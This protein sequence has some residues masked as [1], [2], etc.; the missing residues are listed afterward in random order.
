MLVR[1]VLFLMLTAVMAQ[2]P[3]PVSIGE[4]HYRIFRGDGTAATLEQLVAEA[5]AG[6]VTF[7][8]EL[9]DD[10]V[11]HYL[12]LR[13][14]REMWTPSLALSLEM[15]ETD[16]QD[17]LD[18]YLAGLITEQ[19][20]V[21]ASRPWRNYAQDYRPLIEFAKE[22]KMA[23]VAANAPR[24]YVNRVSRLGASALADVG[25]EGRRFLAPLPHA[26]SSERYGVKF[27]R[28]MEEH[29]EQGKPPSPETIGRSLEAQGLWDATM[30]YSIAGFM[31]RHP[32]RKVLHINGSFHTAEHLGVVEH[33]LRYRPHTSAV[34][35]TIV[36]EKSFPA[37]E[38]K[39]MQGQGTFVIVTDPTLPRSYRTETR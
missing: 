19:H 9:H 35:V 33:L 24:R 5:K 6:D 13:I 8:G 18:E 22:K 3:K 31:T 28:V 7:V 20:F 14:L 32:G 1:S 36:S 21:A 2:D 37:F 25:P 39:N 38:S 23:V 27:R 34:V 17:V 26:E 16:V 10:P 11:A 15:F 29:R 30:A 12:E 4:E